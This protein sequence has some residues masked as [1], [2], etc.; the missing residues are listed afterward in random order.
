[1]LF[2]FF[3]HFLQPKTHTKYCNK[4]SIEK[5]DLQNLNI[6]SFHFYNPGGV[7]GIF[8]LESKACSTTATC[9]SGG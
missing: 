3:S 2:D 8:G 7:L 6:L 4:E 5:E 9:P 1:M